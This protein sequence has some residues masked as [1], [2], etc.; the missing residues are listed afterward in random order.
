L[1]GIKNENVENFNSNKKSTNQKICHSTIGID[2]VNSDQREYK[3]KKGKE[4]RNLM[5]EEGG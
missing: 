4:Y 5:E 3:S 2:M 1:P